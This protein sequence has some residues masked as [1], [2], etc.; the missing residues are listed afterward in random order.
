MSDQ[1]N[2]PTLIGLPRI[3]LDADPFPLT[4]YADVHVYTPSHERRRHESTP[5]MI[6]P[7]R[8]LTP[9]R[10]EQHRALIHRDRA[11]DEPSAWDK[12]LACVIVCYVL[13]LGAALSTCQF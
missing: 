4:P 11:F 2:Q 10:V 9:Q 13:A 7:A 6:P 1:R 8:R 3:E 5:V 12:R